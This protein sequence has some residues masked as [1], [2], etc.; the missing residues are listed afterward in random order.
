[1]G[2]TS[3]I[4][5]CAVYVQYAIT[6]QLA[7]PWGGEEFEKRYPQTQKER[8]NGIFEK[9]MKKYHAQVVRLKIL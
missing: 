3:M 4:A 8:K 9:N 2:I 6:R 1:M 5:K 7:R